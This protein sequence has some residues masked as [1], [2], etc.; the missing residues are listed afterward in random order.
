MQNAEGITVF[1]FVEDDQHYQKKKEDIVKL[2]HHFLV[3]PYIL[4]GVSKMSL[5]AVCVLGL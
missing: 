3:L 1:P 5:N 2:I 4:M